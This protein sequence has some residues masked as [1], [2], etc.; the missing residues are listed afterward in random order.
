MVF[1]VRRE[2]ERE[3]EREKDRDGVCILAGSRCS[4][5]SLASVTGAASAVKLV[6]KAVARKG[7][8]EGRILLIRIGNWLFFLSGYGARCGVIVR[9][10][11]LFL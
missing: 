1:F 8:V 7:I 6:D 4:R 9:C 5:F 10:E 3:R 2:R 11:G